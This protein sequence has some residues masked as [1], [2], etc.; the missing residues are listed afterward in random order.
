MARKRHKPAGIV[1][2]LRRVEALAARGE[3][4]AEGARAIG[5]AEATGCRRR[6]EHGGPEL[7][8]VER[9]EP[10][11]RENGRLRKAVAGLAP[12]KPVLEEAASG[13]P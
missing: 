2:E 8:R 11:E 1:A 13:S 10:L 4:V 7:D 3:T 5:V 9:L 12:E 6:S